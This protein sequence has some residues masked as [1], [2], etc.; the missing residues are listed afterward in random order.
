MTEH[1]LS[2]GEVPYNSEPSI[3]PASIPVRLVRNI[4]F[5]DAMIDL[6]MRQP[7]GDVAKVLEMMKVY[8]LSAQALAAATSML[9]G[10]KP[11]G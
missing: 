2:A 7:G 4:A 5:M 10:I 6:E 8:A 1:D 9:A 11:D 3:D